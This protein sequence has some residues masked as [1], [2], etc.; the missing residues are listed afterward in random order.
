MKLQVNGKEKESSAATLGQ[1]ID[2][3]ELPIESLV[4]EHNAKIVKQQ[5]WDRTPL[6][7]SDT[8]E[9]LNFVGGG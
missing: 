9:L 4:V 6:R 7:E 2:E 8:I 5:E 3:L 1:L